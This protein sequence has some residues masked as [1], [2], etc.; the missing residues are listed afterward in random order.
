MGDQIDEAWDTNG[1]KAEAYRNAAFKEYQAIHNPQSLAVNSA[2]VG[3]D[4]DNYLE[5]VGSAG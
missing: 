1:E 2:E 4:L 3:K 5:A